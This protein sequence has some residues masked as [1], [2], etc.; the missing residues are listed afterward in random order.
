[1]EHRCTVWYPCKK[2][3]HIDVHEGL[4]NDISAK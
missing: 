4:F 2:K 1:M 3:S